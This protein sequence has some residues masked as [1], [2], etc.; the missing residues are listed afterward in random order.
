MVVIISI[1]ACSAEEDPN[2]QKVSKS[3]DEIVEEKKKRKVTPNL[4]MKR[5]LRQLNNQPMINLWIAIRKY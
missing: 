1:S 2:V 3:S 4:L 5:V